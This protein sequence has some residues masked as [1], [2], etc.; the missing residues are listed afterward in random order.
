MAK[1]KTKA[2]KSIEYHLRN[3]ETYKT[4]IRNLNK[5]LE[6]I[7]PDTTANYE[8]A[9][10]SNGTFN[11]TSK[12]E[13]YA[14]DRIESR[15]AL[16]LY[17]DIQRYQIILDSIDESLKVLDDTEQEFVRLRYF[18]GYPVSKVAQELDFSDKHIFNIRKG[19]F[20][21][22]VIALRGILQF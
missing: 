8:L 4:A 13:K 20:D 3:Y 22:L 15:K 6:Y 14:I 7:M 16:E 2:I 11:I 18:K 1:Q 10:G 9:D 19:V 17:E 5:Q 12:T 21:K